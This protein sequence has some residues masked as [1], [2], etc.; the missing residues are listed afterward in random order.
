MRNAGVH[1]ADD[2]CIGEESDRA[3]CAAVALALDEQQKRHAAVRVDAVHRHHV[4]LRGV[5]TGRSANPVA[6]AMREETSAH[7]AACSERIAQLLWL[8]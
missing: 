4:G 1:E 7:D 8:V 5:Q 2:A 6:C 3:R